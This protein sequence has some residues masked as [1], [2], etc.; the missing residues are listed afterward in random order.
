MHI[1][2]VIY[3]LQVDIFSFGMLLFELITGQR[4]FESMSTGQEVNRAV[5][6]RERPQVCEGNMEPCFPGMIELMEDCWRHLAADRP[7]ADEVSESNLLLTVVIVCLLLCITQSFNV[8]VVVF[9]KFSDSFIES[10]KCVLAC[11]C[12]Y[13]VYFPSGCSKDI[14]SWFSMSSPHCLK[15][16]A[17]SSTKDRHHI[18]STSH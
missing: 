5:I 4:P 2:L 6:Q 12:Y 18:L 8:C 16:S 17:A 11:I 13:Y 14:S 3:T 9:S 15:S 1:F 10:L 7:T